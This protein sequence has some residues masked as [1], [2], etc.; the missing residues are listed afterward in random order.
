MAVIISYRLFTTSPARE[1]TRFVFAFFFNH[2]Y[3]NFIVKRHLASLVLALRH[4]EN[5]AHFN[6][7]DFS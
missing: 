3:L 1:K 6:V 4:S 2:L 7:S 5:A